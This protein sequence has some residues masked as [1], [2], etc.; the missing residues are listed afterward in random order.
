MKKF[1]FGA[2][3]LLTSLSC[4]N[5]LEG[6]DA[7]V[8]DATSRN[9]SGAEV[10][11]LTVNDIVR[12]YQGITSRERSI[13]VRVKNLG[14]KKTLSVFGEL[15]S[16]VW[17]TLRS[18]AR[19]L[20]PAGEGYEL[21]SIFATRNAFHGDPKWAD[22]FVIRYDVNGATYWDNNGGSNHVAAYHAGPGMAPAAGNIRLNFDSYYSY[23]HSVGGSL[24]VR[25]LSPDKTIKIL[26]TADSWASSSIA[27][28]TYNSQYF[29]SYGYPIPSPNRYS[30]EYWT[31]NFDLPEGSSLQDVEY[32]IAYEV[33]GVTYWDNN[34]GNNYAP[35]KN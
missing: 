15:E 3:I 32:A 16:G 19:Y 27:Y 10:E 17:D 23:N 2:F 22:E 31:F 21:W 29:P 5:I 8:L 30:V 4:S 33:N 20:G 9:L 11:M 25:N 12:S 1:L 6:G 7:S 13:V 26:Y 35:G 18:N 14:F 28:A 34:F 24:F